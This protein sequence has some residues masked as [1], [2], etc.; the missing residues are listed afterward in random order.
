MSAV[1]DFVESHELVDTTLGELS[2]Y[3]TSGSRDWSKYYAD[4]GAMFIRTQDINQNRLSLDGIA[5]VK[6]PAKVEGKRSLVRRG[7][8]LITITGANVGKVA[9]VENDLPE[10]YVSQSVCLVRLKDPSLAKF[11]QLQ[12]I[13][14][15]GD[16]SALEAMAY[17][18]GRPVLNLDNVRCAPVKVGPPHLRNGIVGEIEKQFSRL[19][20][21][22]ASLRRIK[23][24]LKRYEAAVL[25]AAVE[26]Q[27]VSTEADIARSASRTYETAAELLQNTLLARRR[28]WKGRGR[29]I[30]PRL[31]D[32]VGRR[33]LPEGWTWASLDQLTV[34][35]RGASPRPAGDPRYFGGSTPWI[36]VG[37]ITADE[38]VYLHG[39]PDSVTEEGKKR[40]RFVDPHT[41]LLTNSGA[42]LGIPKITLIG[43][44]IN[45]GV[46]ALLDVEYPMKVYIL[47]FLRTRTASLRRI[48]QGAA[49]PN[50]NTSIIKNI[51][52]PLPPLEEQRRIIAEVE[53]RLSFIR[54]ANMQVDVAIE[55]ARVLRASVLVAAF[56]SYAIA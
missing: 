52:V 56:S 11:L 44:C 39:V 5:Y 15:R 26:G 36:T 53:R 16:K 43:G 19:D 41:L 51:A 35:V 1:A 54:E 49:Q 45:D 34:V 13:A 37:P 42:T 25:K 23:A 6:L 40:S 46:A 4:S 30:E 33:S 18:L 7:D 21:S 31:P 50:L 32:V 8:L 10:A 14:R 2:E 27:L 47:Y 24:S 3:I 22:V 38:E 28:Q 12:L 20:E 17:G 9:V 48:N 55:R 29:Y